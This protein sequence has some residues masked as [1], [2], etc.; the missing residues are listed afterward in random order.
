MYKFAINFSVIIMVYFLKFM[1]FKIFLDDLYVTGKKTE[2]I[3]QSGYGPIQSHSGCYEASKS[4]SISLWNGPHYAS[5]DDRLPYCWVGANGGANYNPNDD[6]GS[7]S[8]VSKLICKKNRK[9]MLSLKNK[10]KS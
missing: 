5:S 10:R 3:C 1:S 4:L 8:R 9:F 7:N 2:E 6:K